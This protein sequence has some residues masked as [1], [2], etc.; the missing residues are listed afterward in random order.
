MLSPTKAAQYPPSNVAPTDP[1]SGLP[2]AKPSPQA[3]PT[4]SR[5]ARKS[6]VRMHLAAI[7]VSGV[8]SWRQMLLETP[9]SAKKTANSPS[10]A[11]KPAEK[12]PRLDAPKPKLNRMQQ[13]IQNME[14]KY[15]TARPPDASRGSLSLKR[16][17]RGEGDAPGLKRQHGASG[18]GGSAP[19]AEGLLGGLSAAAVG[20]AEAGTSAADDA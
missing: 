16:R 17:K 15:A 12:R 9:L 11:D 20:A 6:C 2:S 4:R 10:T 8:I 1:H 19:S 5:E 3:T 14:R 7:P 13:I 18:A